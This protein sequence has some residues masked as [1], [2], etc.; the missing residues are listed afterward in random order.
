MAEKPESETGFKLS[1]LVDD[2][3]VDGGFQL[4]P[5]I[6][7]AEISEELEE[8]V[9]GDGESDVDV[10]GF[11]VDWDLRNAPEPDDLSGD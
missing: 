2:D 9:F 10:P 8:I 5:D 6:S 7:E 11:A 4:A 3:E 1:K